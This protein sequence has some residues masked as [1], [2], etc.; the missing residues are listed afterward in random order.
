MIKDR[1]HLFTNLINKSND[2]IFVIDPVT[3]SFLHANDTACI[4]LGYT[5]EEILKLGVKDIHAVEEGG[6]D[7][8]KQVRDLRK[9]G[10]VLREG[11]V[12]GKNGRRFSVE[13]NVSYLIQDDRDYLIS[14][15]RDISERKQ[16]EKALKEMNSRLD[17][18]IQAIPDLVCFKDADGKYLVVNK[19]TEQF[20]GRDWKEI[21]GKTDA[22][23]L[24]PELAAACRQSDEASRKRGEPTLAE[25]EYRGQ[26]GEV[27]CF[28]TVKAPIS[29][30]H[31]RAAGLVAISRDITERKKT[32]DALRQS[33]ERLAQAQAMAHI[34]NWEWD[35]ATN[36]VFWSDEVY[37]IYGYEPHEVG[38]DYELVLK[39]LH[40]ETKKL[41]LEAID[42]ALRGV[43]PFEMDYVFLT[44]D[45]KKK[46][47]HTIGKVFRDEA[48][49]PARM[50]GT[51]QDIT[52]QK[53]AEEELRESEGRFRVL[54]EGAPDAAF[55]GET[56]TGRIIDANP[57]ACRLL[58]RSRE[59]ILGLNQKELHPPN[60]TPSAQEL[61][62]QH[63]RETEKGGPAIFL[64]SMVLRS[65][66]KEVPVEISAQRVVIRGRPVLYGVFR[67]I[68]RRKQ[69]EAMVRNILETV[70]EAFIIIDRDYR[71]IS[72]NRAY[73]RQAN[74]PVEEI[75]GKHC[76]RISHGSNVPCHEAG[77]ECAVLHT[78]EHGEPSTVV[79]KHHDKDG[80][81]L[82]VE[83]KSYPMRDASGDVVSAIEVINNITEKHLLEEQ[84]LRNQKL[85]AVGLLA[86]GIAH[87]FNNLLQGVFGGISLAKQLAGK[88]DPIYR[89]LENAEGALNLSRSLTRQLLTFS[90]GGEPVKRVISLHSV[91]LDAAK[92]ALSGSG[93]DFQSSIDEGLWPVEADE[94]QISQVIQ[95]I[96]LNASNAMPNGGAVTI[97]ACN[98][99]AD[100]DAKSGLEKGDY[101]KITI[102]DTG[103]GI[104]ESHLARIFDP[105]FTTKEKGTGLGLATSYSIVKRHSGLLDVHSELGRGSVFAVYLPA[106]RGVSLPDRETRGRAPVK[107]S[108]RILFMDDEEIVRNVARYMLESLGYEPDF[109]VH[110]DEAVSKY[111]K[112]MQAGVP[113]GA[114]ILDLTIR[115]GMGGV[116]TIKRIREQDPAVKAIVS[117][118]YS[119]EPFA[120]RYEEMG[121]QAVLN[122][123]Y[124][125]ESL[126]RV[127]HSLLNNGNE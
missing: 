28:E 95:N 8:E 24:P 121:F 35:V 116:E 88:A 122:K 76:Y 92:F 93:V 3:G 9:K 103:P 80:N 106:S 110:G 49:K 23:L 111:L 69:A 124:E 57:A 27:R 52:E 71:I 101:V 29:D 97:R 19:A 94:G 45:G 108:G 31:G 75:L 12:E 70:D 47:L 82:Y 48:G 53:R 59:Q 123:P 46:T 126:G 112:A 120:Q 58:L 66:G 41:F 11:E 74:L 115:G 21:E 127:L 87:D 79:H 89:H 86:G 4:K 50:V 119:D 84:M 62:E 42:A 109:A 26:D 90:K 2:A 98:L 40:P 118:G 117:S 99:P 32:G 54:F 81:L 13:V 56:D 125:A 18:L 78:F 96:V 102:E 105:Y 37:R 30:G 64:E 25:E 113:Y 36:K 104:P 51:V 10:S 65:D 17:T 22:D 63:I 1:L 7:W 20:L 43:R 60:M 72:A 67:D 73:A 39:A 5:R 33:E 55:L 6:G 83:T 77:E 44:K 61:F 114:V 91:V 85:E 14:I 68:S 100:G 107:G 34:G 15:V 16:S 38:P